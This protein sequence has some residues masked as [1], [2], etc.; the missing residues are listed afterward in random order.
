MLFHTGHPGGPWEGA[1]AQM[2]CGSD[3]FGGSHIGNRGG[4]IREAGGA[5]K[6]ESRCWWGSG[7]HAADRL[8]H[9]PARSADT[10]CMGVTGVSTGRFHTTCL[11][12]WKVVV[13]FQA[14]LLL[15]QQTSQHLPCASTAGGRTQLWPKRTEMALK[16]L[17]AGMGPPETT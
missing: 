13:L 12:R 16:N 17:T 5:L 8:G 2:K 15:I 10:G 6:E 9:R 7:G 11:V 3:T 14:H 1:E 4:V